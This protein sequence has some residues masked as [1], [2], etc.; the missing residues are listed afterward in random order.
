MALW[1]SAV[2]CAE[3]SEALCKVRSMLSYLG[4]TVAFCN[5]NEM[6]AVIL[7]HKAKPA[8]RRRALSLGVAP[9]YRRL[10][11]SCVDKC[12]MLRQ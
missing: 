3:A 4:F 12:A 7:E 10:V 9:F 5:N 8:R 6:R 11:A 1:P 2:E